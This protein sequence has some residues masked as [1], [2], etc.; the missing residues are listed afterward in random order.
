MRNREESQEEDRWTTSTKIDKNSTRTVVSWYRTILIGGQLL[1]RQKP[2]KVHESQCNKDIN[3]NTKKRTYI[4]IHIPRFSIYLNTIFYCSFPTLFSHL[5]SF[6]PSGFRFIVYLRILSNGL[7]GVWQVERYLRSW[8]SWLFSFCFVILRSLLF[9]IMLANT[10]YS[11]TKFV[12]KCLQ[13]WS[14]DVNFFPCFVNTIHI[15]NCT[16]L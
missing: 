6:E 10:Y 5:N 7:H 12:S 11:L 15:S 3:N 9:E 1:K 14:F 4:F 13:L 8:I 2:Y 16:K